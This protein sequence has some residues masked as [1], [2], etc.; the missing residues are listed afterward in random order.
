[1]K[2]MVSIS[3]KLLIFV[4][5]IYIL[6]AKVEVRIFRCLGTSMDSTISNGEIIVSV[7]EN[8]IKR[9]DIV[10]FNTEGSP[11]IKRVVGLPKET[12]EIKNDGNVYIDDKVYHENY[13]GSKTPKGEIS[14]PHTIEEN[15]YFLLGDN[16]F[17]S[18]D[19]R[20][21]KVGDVNINK[22]RGRVVF[23]I[24]RFKVV[25]RMNY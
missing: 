20:Y 14:F 18:Y 11:A 19:S 4:A 23:S 15:S 24:T 22:I 8:N 17:D 3:I 16:R 1:M 21:H 12:I 5:I 2:K 6:Y 9:G 10:V 13:I 7:K 25:N